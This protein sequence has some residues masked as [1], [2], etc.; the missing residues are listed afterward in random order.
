MS[1]HPKKGVPA[2]YDSGPLKGL[3]KLDDGT[4]RTLS[5]TEL[6]TELES[7]LQRHAKA[8]DENPEQTL[9]ETIREM[10]SRL[11]AECKRLLPTAARNA[12]QGKPALLRLISRIV[13][14]AR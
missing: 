14:S 9:Q 7:Q 10:R 13:R 6:L 3:P 11:L 8:L 4:A 5:D 12:R 1:N 2:T